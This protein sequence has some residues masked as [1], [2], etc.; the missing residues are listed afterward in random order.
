MRDLPR[1]AAL[2]A[3][4]R[5]GATTDRAH[6]EE[7]RAAGRKITAPLHFLHAQTGFPARTER[8]KTAWQEWAEAVTVASCRTGHFVMEE[9]PE[10]VLAAFLPHVAS[11]S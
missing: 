5:A 3:D 10:A 1:V 6:D 8:V 9:N 2:C 7:D 4:Y 11:P